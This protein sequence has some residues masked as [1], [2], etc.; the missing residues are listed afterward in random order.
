LASLV[1]VASLVSASRVAAQDIWATPPETQTP[2]DTQNAEPAKSEAAQPKE[3]PRAVDSRP[4]VDTYEARV[5]Y[6]IRQIVTRDFDGAIETLRRAA[7]IEA[8]SPVAFCHLGDA[9]LERG[10]AGEARAAYETCA[11]FAGLENERYQVLAQVG[12]ARV[13]EK[14]QGDLNEK[15]TAWV[16]ARDAVNEP[17]AKGLAEA[18]I[19]AYDA[20]ITREKAHE[21]VR[22]RIVERDVARESMGL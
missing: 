19:A 20:A 1:L 8:K 13:V 17:A 11:R 5:L 3:Q 2:P 21:A 18:L 9:E 6:G 12:L 14:G 16:R 22:R 15:R 10:N 7:Q 4:E